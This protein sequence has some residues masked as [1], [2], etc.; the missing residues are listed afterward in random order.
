MVGLGGSGFR[1]ALHL[2]ARLQEGQYDAENLRM[3]VV[4]LPGQDQLEDGHLFREGE[5]ACV[6]GAGDPSGQEWIS[7]LGLSPLTAAPPGMTRPLGRLAFLRNYHSEVEPKLRSALEDTASSG[8]PGCPLRVF[9]VGSSGG[10]SGGALV[11]DMAE[12]VRHLA[13][14]GTVILET[15][16]FLPSV[17]GDDLRDDFLKLEALKSNTYATLLELEHLMA[18]PV[19]PGGNSLIDR[20][21]LLGMNNEVLDRLPTSDDMMAMVAESL[22]MD[23]LHPTDD[24]WSQRRHEDDRWQDMQ[25]LQGHGRVFSS[26]GVT[27]LVCSEFSLQTYASLRMIDE[28][29]Q[30][31]LLPGVRDEQKL[32]SSATSFLWRSDLEE[33]RLRND[34]VRAVN[35]C[36][37]RAP[38][39]DFSEQDFEKAP[40]G[41]FP[42]VFESLET[43]EAE[44]LTSHVAEDLRERYE[45]WLLETRTLVHF[46]TLT[47]FRGHG[48][49]SARHWC[50]D[51]LTR[52]AGTA[53]HL[54][55]EVTQLRENERRYAKRMQ[56]CRDLADET[57]RNVFMLGRRERL[58]AIAREYVREIRAHY[59]NAIELMV[60][61]HAIVMLEALY[62]DLEHLVHR[63]GIIQTQ[64]EIALHEVEGLLQQLASA[65]GSGR[66][67]GFEINVLG[68][69]QMEAWYQARCRDHIEALLVRLLESHERELPLDQFEGRQLL[70]E[71]MLPQARAYLPAQAMPERVLDLMARTA[72]PPDA[73]RF[74]QDAD[75]PMGPQGGCAAWLLL[76]VTSC[77]PFWVY[78]RESLGHEAHPFESYYLAARD[79][80]DPR[81][82]DFTDRAHGMAVLASRDARK[83]S[84]RA[85]SHGLPAF[86][87][88]QIHDWKLAYDQAVREK[89]RPLHL[90]RAWSHLS[91]LMPLE[92][93]E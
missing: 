77:R 18:N 17:Y 3:L 68:L 33:Q 74:L 58:M 32:Q 80:A 83:I 4:A 46:E 60:R 55:D 45:H 69:E 11:P 40:P 93:K 62:A 23:S 6:G 64:L 29:L 92:H 19:R 73:V 43:S 48:C 9:L 85:E 65:N 52:L 56:R 16:L 41:Q 50:H 75:V 31:R 54:D 71:F 8:L 82:R 91:D 14:H 24:W 22:L 79:L 38:E 7:E 35:T 67:G 81:L 26:F 34:C 86:V 2:R 53:R 25:P 51:I 70:L 15:I 27:T 72:L 76:A 78:N 5:Y 13:P 30:V 87:L 28:L 39:S 42:R 63:L 21:H 59:Q 89:R 90:C 47:V 88:G 1:V 44:H 37:E 36:L 20:C 12:A 10:P 66:M 57:L 49:P 84:F 61:D